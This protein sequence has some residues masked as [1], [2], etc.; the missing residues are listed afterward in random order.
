MLTNALYTEMLFDLLTL[1]F[2]VSN[3]D[4]NNNLKIER[5]S[6]QQ[7]Y[8]YNETV[9]TIYIIVVS[10]E[11]TDFHKYGVNVRHE[12]KFVREDISKQ[13]VSRLE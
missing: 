12:N 2:E 1:A 7:S 6:R 9:H 10:V 4:C 5:H 3:N 8:K 11:L 13:N